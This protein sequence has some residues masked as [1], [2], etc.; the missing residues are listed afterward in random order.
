MEF[1][2]MF[3]WATVLAALA[4]LGIEEKAS[5]PRLLDASEGSLPFNTVAPFLRL[6]STSTV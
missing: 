5:N 4:S 1:S 6:H 2:Y 3:W